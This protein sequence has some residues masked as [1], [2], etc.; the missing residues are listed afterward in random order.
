LQAIGRQSNCSKGAKPL[1][2]KAMNKTITVIEKNVYGNTLI[3]PL[4]E[5][6][7]KFAELIGKKTFSQLDLSRIQGLG[8][9]VLNNSTASLSPSAN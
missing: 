3:Y 8:Y 7:K 4:C 6:A 9:L 1:K 5:T 2:L